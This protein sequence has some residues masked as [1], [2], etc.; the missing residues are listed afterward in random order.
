MDWFKHKVG[1]HEDPDIS[2][3]WDKFGNKAYV[4]F[5]VLLEIYAR[6]FRRKNDTGG[7]TFSKKYLQRKIR[8]KWAVIEELLVF[9]E[10]RGRL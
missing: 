8:N 6:E 10:K 2:D 3:A 4:I 7:I 9:Y 1:S 5:F